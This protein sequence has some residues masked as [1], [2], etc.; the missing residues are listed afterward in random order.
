MKQLV[1][2]FMLI[3]ILAGLIAA[4]GAT[5]PTTAPTVAPAAVP[6]TAAPV[7]TGSAQKLV[8]VSSLPRVNG[9]KPQ[10]DSIVNAIKQRLEEAQNQACG[11]TFSIEYRDW[12][13]GAAEVGSDPDAE[14]SN[15]KKAAAD[16]D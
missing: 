16:A 13:D 1:S 2:V 4:C 8:F 12:D 15:A 6:A 5:K 10:T 9:S 3:T 14:S 11:G 7:A